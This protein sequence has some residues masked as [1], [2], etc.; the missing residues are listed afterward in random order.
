[1]EIWKEIIYAPNYEVSNLGNIKNKTTKRVKKLNYE[2]MKKTNTRARVGL[3][4]DGKGKNYY[5]HRIVAQ[6][7]LTNINNYNEV[8][9]KD[10]DVYNNKLDNL[11]WVSKKQ[12]MDHA[13]KNKLIK[14]Y[15][16]KIVVINKN[17]NTEQI[18]D[19][20]T[21][22][23]KNFKVWP[24]VISS[25]CK[26]TLV[27]SKRHGALLKDFTFQYENPD[28][29]YDTE[30]A[31]W[32]SYPEHD[33]YLVSNTGLVKN[34]KTKRILMGSK[35]N[36]YKFITMHRGK[37]KSNLN[38]LIHRMVAQTFLPNPDNKPVVNHKDTDVLNNSVS[39]LEWVTY[40][41]N[42][43]TAKTLENCKKG[44]SNALEM[45]GRPVLKIEIETGKIQ[46]FLGAAD[47]DIGASAGSVAS[48]CGFY[49]KGFTRTSV[50]A[51]MKTYKKKYIFI[52]KDDA[53]KIPQFLKIAKEDHSKKK[54]AVI[55]LDK[56][57]LNFINS[58][59]SMYSAAK[60]LDISHS[61]ISQCCNYY[62][63]EDCNRPK[64]YKLKTYKGFVFKFQVLTP[65]T[66]IA[67]ADSVKETFDHIHL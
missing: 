48:I 4:N 62:K 19:S 40:K 12:N 3:S 55:Q 28:I 16:R 53:K 2:R 26:K 14:R 59:E 31:I 43:N 30:D 32:E 41:E 39:N 15:T 25:I 58:Y 9:H 10:G 7:F 24:S 17:D 54:E 61:G 21:T 6:H 65:A 56:Y 49:N 5:L 50:K 44:K 42:M 60:K 64:C 45:C 8:N 63:Y 51:G 11:E 27:K 36:G 67:V 33:K 57:T 13:N 37:G 20:L 34:K 38:R 1:M 47:K 23:A 66:E 22:C 29:V 35:V 18:F 52:F 46:E